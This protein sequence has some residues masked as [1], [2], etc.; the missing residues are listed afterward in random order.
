MILGITGVAGAGKDT[1][2]SILKKVARASY[3]VK[4]FSLADKLKE[5]CK[6]YC[7]NKYGIDPTNCSIEE[8]NKIRNTLVSHAKRKRQETDGR[9]WI[10][11]IEKEIKEFDSPK[12]I[13]VITDIRYCD[14]QHDELFW[15]KNELNGKLLYIG[16]YEVNEDNFKIFLK[17]ANEEELRNDPHLYMNS[18]YKI[19]WRT[20]SE[21]LNESLENHVKNFLQQYEKQIDNN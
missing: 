6:E 3:E 14:Y 5:E 18:D 1:F 4:R 12:T 19:Q 15:L 7:I 21:E 8:K 16:R 10:S 13:A 2:F 11:R 17:G 9:Y 20:V